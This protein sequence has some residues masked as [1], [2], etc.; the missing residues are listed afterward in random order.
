MSEVRRCS[1][2]GIPPELRLQIYSYVLGFDT[3]RLAIYDPAF[4]S[5]YEWRFRYEGFW[6]SKDGYGTRIIRHQPDLPR[7]SWLCLQSTCKLISTELKSHMQS[8]AI[9]ENEEHHNYE[10][11]ITGRRGNLAGV[12]WN[13][14]PC[15]PEQCRVLTANITLRGEIT[16]WGDGGPMPIIR[17]LYQT[18]NR[19]LHCGPMLDAKTPL[20]RSVKLEG[21]VV[22]I[23]LRRDSYVFIGEDAD[24]ETA[25]SLWQHRDGQL[26]RRLHSHVGDLVATGLLD[27]FIKRIV[28][29]NGRSR[30]ELGQVQVARKEGP[31]AV[32]SLWDRYGFE[33]GVERS[34]SASASGP[35]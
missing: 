17:E 33:W 19:F 22:V 16:L 32:P 6:G 23:N 2:L 10:M 21:V 26:L 13:S 34:D 30:E 18:L 35:E 11:T 5:G 29:V 3:G 12:V 4:D 14:L 9:Y 24:P 31:G 7:I 28:L 27:G 20:R 25:E 15:P 8:T 1:L